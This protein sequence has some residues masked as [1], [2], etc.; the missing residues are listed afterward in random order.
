MKFWVYSDI[1]ARTSSLYPISLQQL[2]THGLYFLVDIFSLVHRQWQLVTWSRTL[3]VETR[4]ALIFW[5]LDIGRVSFIQQWCKMEITN[6]TNSL[7]PSRP[8]PCKPNLS[9]K[10]SA[11]SIASIIGEDVCT[12]EKSRSPS[13]LLDLRCGKNYILL[14]KTIILKL[15]LA[16]SIICIFISYVHFVISSLLICNERSNLFSKPNNETRIYTDIVAVNISIATF[17][18]RSMYVYLYCVIGWLVG[19]LGYGNLGHLDA[20]VPATKLI[21]QTQKIQYRSAKLTVTKQFYCNS[22]SKQ[23][24][25]SKWVI[26]KQ[27]DIVIL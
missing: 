17:Y 3:R 24:I 8:S 14:F 5:L 22:N 11:F 18:T 4:S 15:L 2:M 25:I 21:E 13:P 16:L 1:V 27:T 20:Y 9:P 12:E 6:D 19:W 23:F 26:L 7:E 10:A